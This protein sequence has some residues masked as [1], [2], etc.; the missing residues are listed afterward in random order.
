MVGV[1]LACAGLLAFNFWL[2]W[3]V[4]HQAKEEVEVV[5]KR[6]VALAE[7][8]IG[9]VVKLVNDLSLR[10]LVSCRPAQLE[11][12]RQAALSV[13]LIKEI[14]I[15]AAD[16]QT[17]CST[18]GSFAAQRKV[19]SSQRVATDSDIL[20]EV[21]DI[22]DID[23]NM[24][25]V[26]RLGAGNVPGLGIMLLG[27]RVV[28][29]RSDEVHSLDA[30]GR[31][32]LQDGTLLG[33]AGAPAEGE[34]D[35][36]DRLAMS[37]PS[38]RYGMKVSTSL[39]KSELYERASG[40]RSLG[41]AITG[42]VAFVLLAF[43]FFVPKRQRENPI[44]EI[45]RALNAGEF[46]PYYQPVVDLVSGKLRGAEVLIRW[47]KPDGSTL[48]PA[49]FIPL[50]ESSGIILDMTRALM[51][52]VCQEIG[53]AYAE[54][55]HLKVSFNLAARH[56][57]KDT[58]L[59]DVRDI[60]GSGSVRFSQLVLELTE[61][62]PIENLAE[63]RRLIAKLQGMGVRMAIDDVGTGHSGLSYILKLGVDIIKIDK[64]FV[65]AIGIER[66][67]TTIIET[68]IDLANN[69]RM[70]VIAEGVENFEQVA[71]LRDRGIRAAQGFVFAPPLPG[72]SFLQLIE[73]IDP[74][75]AE[76]APAREE[77]RAA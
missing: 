6:K 58:I 72:S 37:L 19:L 7:N 29:H 21:I 24:V 2:D 5:A 54:R 63:T 64:M 51:R 73:A 77:E 10:G 9:R 56:F 50:A 35:K 67:S 17:L 40:I 28:A 55:P 43:S 3:L 62:Q 22:G 30:H 44:A 16:G 48:S 53:P 33:E 12:L 52:R 15:I 4:I 69:M 49:V 68:L 8:R 66:G 23:E 13:G 14:S 61:R 31:A 57:E 18:L 39:P 36:D 45:E 38:M 70:E 42:I 26:R 59:R 25:R 75:S 34:D 47:R 1:F 76:S 32:T 74:L 11:A 20:I 41:L 60:F 46:V 27:S 65:D 71:C